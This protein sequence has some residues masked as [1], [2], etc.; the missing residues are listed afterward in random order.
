MH[1]I[2][3][4]KVFIIIIKRLYY[5]MKLL[6]KNIKNKIPKLGEQESNDLNAIAYVK[7]FTPWSN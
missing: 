5:K 2:N 7:F 6:P 1:L 3:Y 4:I